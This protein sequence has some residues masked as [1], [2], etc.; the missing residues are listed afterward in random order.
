MSTPYHLNH[1]DISLFLILCRLIIIPLGIILPTSSASEHTLMSHY[2]NSYCVI[3]I[4]KWH[5]ILFYLGT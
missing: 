4:L 2:L 5:G 3:I 1:I